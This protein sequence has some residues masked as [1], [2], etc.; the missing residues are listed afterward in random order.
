MRCPEC[1]SE[2]TDHPRDDNGELPG[3]GN[4]CPRCADTKGDEAPNL[5]RIDELTTY[6]SSDEYPNG[7]KIVVLRDQE[8]L[9]YDGDW[10]FTKPNGRGLSS[11]PIM[12]FRSYEDP[13]WRHGFSDTY[14]QYTQQLLASAVLRMGFEQMSNNV[15]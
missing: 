7:R 8:H 12:E 4:P 13:R 2:Y 14:Y 15:D 9:L 6:Q 5:D 1:A 10:G 11:F 3:I